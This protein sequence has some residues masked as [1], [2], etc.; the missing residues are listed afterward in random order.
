MAGKKAKKNKAVEGKVVKK[1]VATPP[2]GEN[3]PTLG[4]IIKAADEVLIVTATK[5]QID[6]KALKNI[7]YAYAAKALLMGAIDNYNNKPII[8]GLNNSSRALLSHIMN[9]NTKVDKVIGNT[10]VVAENKA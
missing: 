1:A 10:P 7:N 8:N 4:D 2:T 3:Q 5:G 9:L 6:V